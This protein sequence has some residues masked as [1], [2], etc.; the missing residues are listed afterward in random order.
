MSRREDRSIE[1][2]VRELEDLAQKLRPVHVRVDL[3]V[4][5]RAREARRPRTI[6][7]I[8]QM[9]DDDP[10]VE[11][12]EVIEG[13]AEALI[14][15][16][17][18][19]RASRSKKP[20]WSRNKDDE[21]F[22]ELAARCE[23]VV[24]TVTLHAAQLLALLSWASV[25]ALLGGNRAGKTRIGLYWLIIRWVLRGSPPQGAEPG[26]LFWIVAP[27]E[28]K[29]W[30]R[31]IA[32]AGLLPRRL[33]TGS[34]PKTH[35]AQQRLRMIDGS[36]FEAHHAARDG[37]NLK[38]E[39]VTDILFDEATA[40]PDPGNLQQCLSRT[41][42]N[43]GAVFCSTTPKAGHYIYTRIVLQAPH[44]GGRIAVFHT[45]LFDN[46]WLT[47]ARIF[48]LFIGD[49]TLTEAELVEQVLT[50]ED[51]AAMCRAIVTNPTSL[52]EHFGVWVAQGLRL[53]S[54]W[55]ETIARTCTRSGQARALERL[56]WAPPDGAPRQ[57]ANVT[58]IAAQ[59]L[60][61]WRRLQ[62]ERLRVLGGQDFN[63]NPQST[64]LAQVFGVPEDPSTW[65]LYVFDEIQTIGTVEAH[66]T[67]LRRQ[68]PGLAIACDPAGDIPRAKQ[69]ATEGDEAA[70]LRDMGFACHSCV[71][72]G[73]RL[74]SQKPT[75]TLVH[76][77][78]KQGRI[79]VHLR[80]RKLLS[81][82][83]TQQAKPDGRIA[84]V[85]GSKSDRESS[86][87]DALRYLAYALF[88]H[89]LQIA[90]TVRI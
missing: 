8:E 76:Y 82:L 41:A 34:L 1:A 4:C 6:A 33:W 58:P 23:L 27:N 20:E 28:K 67:K 5:A 77:L 53:W 90:T 83:E 51:P 73:R 64:I 84:K 31:L 45:D 2:R 38:S 54:D 40:S 29:A 10:V 63:I 22:D 85:S 3:H 80:C 59:A 43:G 65:V 61:P 60:S 42:Q 39:R 47:L 37:D 79:V 49:G 19:A 89:E 55:T 74:Q 72:R 44:S 32:L 36:T 48:D 16:A 7:E 24:I 9:L 62:P 52:R 75:L 12:V 30:K 78:M 15:P 17:T 86:P 68:H 81:A 25:I 35:R 87:T 71:G 66:G 46:P 69:E 50:A 13:W 57:L 11:V 14:D 88:R 18:G 21:G 26:G 56:G 70:R